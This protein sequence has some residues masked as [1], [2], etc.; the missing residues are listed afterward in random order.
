MKPLNLNNQTCDPIASN[1][2]IWT[3][4]DIECIK[5]C[6]G[7]TISDVVYNLATEFCKVLAII[8]YP[9]DL[10][11]F[12]LTACK[13]DDFE[14]LI[15]FLIN[16]VC[17]LET[18][19]G[20]VPDCQ[21]NATMTGT[22]SP[23]RGKSSTSGCPDC[24]VAIA[25]CFYYLNPF[26]D[27]VTSMQLIDYVNAIGNRLCTLAT[28]IT[29]LQTAVSN[30]TIR[31]TNL[32]NQPPP[33]VSLPTLIPNC[34]LSAEQ[35]SMIDV[36]TALETQFCQLQSATGA[37]I[38]LYQNIVKQCAGLNTSLQLNGSG[39]TMASIPGW[40]STVT[41]LAQSFGNSWLAI[42]DM[43]Q[44][45]RNIQ[46]NCCPQGCDGISMSLT[47]LISSSNLTIYPTG[48]IPFGF[49]QCGGSSTQVVVTDSDGNS[50]TFTFDLLSYINN[51]TGYLISL[52]ST[53]I[54]ISLNMTIVIQ[55]CLYNP[56]T[57]ATCQRYLSY[58][59]TN[60]ALC[61]SISFVSTET[62]IAYSFNSNSGDYTYNVQLWNDIASLEL[63][64][65]TTVQ[66]GVA[67]VSGTFSTLTAGTTY[68][69]RVVITPTG[70]GECSPTE[71]MFNIISTD[72]LPCDPPTGVS[73]EI[74]LV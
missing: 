72:P 11:C 57:N 60:S 37:P 26:G 22:T 53:P 18:C 52:V 58:F 36:L 33:Q 23:G 63:D 65:Q 25:P 46:L 55:P 64:N 2:V 17:S 40:T 21:G 51:P 38:S 50:A 39:G 13:P 70:C 42:C 24:V 5:L 43:R 3:G 14:S 12:N 32:E 31:V 28:D 67:I 29:N 49:V 15:Q 16:R 71:C 30:L 35:H 62:T 56:N 8:D 41:N 66:A 7:D 74:N 68:R 69:V 19:T 27:T 47:A 54:N 1:C 20:C 4:P 61:P 73:S 59:I 6:K 45:I 44:A 48:L 10:S 9:Y 34:V